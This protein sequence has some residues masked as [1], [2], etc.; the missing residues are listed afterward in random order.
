MKKLFIAVLALSTLSA[1]AEDMCT[2]K[3]KK[4]AISVESLSQGASVSAYRAS[5]KLKKKVK[6]GG[7]YLRTYTVETKDQRNDGY[8][9]YE[10]SI[11]DSFC[12]VVQKV[13]LITQD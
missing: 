1:F 8:S 12:S 4:V 7:E 3:V 11:F 10:V 6:S 5:A 2:T 9:R 13:E